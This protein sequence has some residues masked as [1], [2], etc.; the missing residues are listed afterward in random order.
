MKFEVFNPP[1][2]VGEYVGGVGG[3]A[4][5]GVRE[6]ERERER[7]RER[8]KE[9]YDKTRGGSQLIAVDLSRL[10][11]SLLSLSLPRWFELVEG[12]PIKRSFTR[13]SALV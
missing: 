1:V 3:W 13:D 4:Q 8:E 2:V 12:V 10:Y 11:G 9:R 7:E 6:K 5:T